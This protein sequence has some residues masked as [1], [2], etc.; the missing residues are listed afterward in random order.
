MLELDTEK[1]L[2]N[3]NFYG[4]RIFFLNESK[5]WESDKLFPNY[6]WNKEVKEKYFYYRKYENKIE[7]LEVKIKKLEKKI[8]ML[9]N[10][11][12][13]FIRWLK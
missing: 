1:Y 8:L 11:K 7:N 5:I 3:F 6:P 9:K 13:R 4:F 2:N 10:K 12:Y